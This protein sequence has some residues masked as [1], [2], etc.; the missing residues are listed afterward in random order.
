MMRKIGTA[1]IFLVFVLRATRKI[2][3]VPIFLV[4][5]AHAGMRVERSSGDLANGLV[6]HWIF[7]V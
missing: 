2:V 1:T 6:G 5:Q 3:A 7:E 4:A